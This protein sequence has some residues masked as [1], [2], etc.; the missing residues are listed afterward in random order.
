[1]GLG[2]VQAQGNNGEASIFLD[3]RPPC[4]CPTPM[5]RTA[6]QTPAGYVYDAL[7]RG[8]ARLKLFRKPADYA[9]FLRVF[10]EALERHPIRV[11]GYCIM[12]TYWHGML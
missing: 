5:P 11:L 10:D 4:D 3:I 7:N 2:P 8:T 12:L 9:A 1:M 6:R